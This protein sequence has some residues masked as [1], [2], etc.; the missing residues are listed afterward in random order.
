MAAKPIKVAL[1]AENNGFVPTGQA[2]AVYPF[3]T[4][5]RSRGVPSQA[6]SRTIR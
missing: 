5:L 6:C 1:M 2:G 4:R 3:L